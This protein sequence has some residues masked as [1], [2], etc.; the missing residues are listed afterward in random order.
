M[1]NETPET[2][3]NKI[4]KTAKPSRLIGLISLSILSVIVVVV[5]VFAI[6]IYGFNWQDNVTQK[7]EKIIPYPV[8]LVNYK[9]IPY[10]SYQSD[11]ATLV[12]YYDALA[13]NGEG[14]TSPSPENLDKAV[15]QR[16]VRNE[17]TKQ[18]AKDYK[19]KVDKI[20]LE[21]EMQK[22]IGQSDNPADAEKTLLNLYNWSTEQYR[23]NVLFYYLL[24]SQ[25]QDKISYDDSQAFNIDAKKKAEEVLDKI[26][27]EAD[28]FEN[29]AKNYS[30]DTS[31]PE[32]GNLGSVTRGQMISEFEEA[33]FSLQKGEVSGLVRTIYGFHIIKVLN[34]NGEGESEE[35]EL[36]HILIKTLDIDTYISE[37]LKD[38]R[39]YVF[40]NG[41]KWDRDAEEA[42]FNAATE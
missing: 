18:I 5:A 10:A 2:K 4:I 13:K 36:A 9:F 7:V 8:A 23:D 42:V 38:T 11:L 32:G 31:A 12:F 29:L 22:I 30:E 1:K 20:E 17:V 34:I 41:M 24:R 16:L 40:K 19:V 25:I 27:G 6:G 33:A 15:I 37:Q 26:K 21:E 28:T 39:V 35:R 14:L 3:E